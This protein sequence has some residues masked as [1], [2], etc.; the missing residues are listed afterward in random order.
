[1]EYKSVSKT[2]CFSYT[3]ESLIKLLYWVYGRTDYKPLYTLFLKKE[4]K[5]IRHVINSDLTSF[6]K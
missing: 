5:K 1:M 2:V 6:V 4:P 3:G